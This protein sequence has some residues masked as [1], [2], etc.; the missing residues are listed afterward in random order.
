[1]PIA[2]C[3]PTLH[4]AGILWTVWLHLLENLSVRSYRLQLC[5]S[6]AVCAPGWTSP[7]SHSLNLQG[8]F[9]PAPSLWHSAECWFMNVFP[10]LGCPNLGTLLQMW[11]NKC[12]IKRIIILVWWPWSCFVA[13]ML[14]AAFAARLY[15][16]LKL[17]AAHW[18]SGSFQKKSSQHVYPQ[19]ALLSGLLCSK[20]RTSCF[21]LLKF[22]R[23]LVTCFS[24]LPRFL[25]AV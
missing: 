7:T 18:A 8:K 13:P 3:P 21:S 19:P 25:W 1:M 5:A 11:S 23:F 22:I 2:P 20:G 16:C 6:E 12:W 14:S 24:S 15:I 10:V 4:L 9:Q 17:F